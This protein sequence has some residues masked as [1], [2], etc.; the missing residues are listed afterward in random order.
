MRPPLNEI[1]VATCDVNR[2]RG[3]DV[4]YHIAFGCFVTRSW[5]TWIILVDIVS[6]VLPL[7]KRGEGMR[8]IMNQ[9]VAETE[10]L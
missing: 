3:V 9:S 7:K 6:L 4:N 10:R 2:P 8:E 5:R 1:V